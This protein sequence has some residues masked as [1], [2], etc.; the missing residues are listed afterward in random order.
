MSHD[1]VLFSATNRPMNFITANSPRP[2]G[3]AKC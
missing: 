2:S 1:A 3:L